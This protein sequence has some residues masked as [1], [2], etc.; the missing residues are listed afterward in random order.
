VKPPVPLGVLRGVLKDV[1]ASGRVEKPLVVGGARELAAVLRKELGRDGARGAVGAGDDVEGAAVLV[2][3]LGHEPGE[4][5]ERALRRARRARVP[6]VAVAAG[7]VPDVAIP[8]VLA[9]D[10]VRVKAG[11]G[12][13]IEAIARTIAARLGEDAA[14]LAARLPVLR[15]AICGWIVASCAR[16][17]AIV[18]VAV[19]FPGAD[20][21]IL[22]RNQVRMLLRLDQ[23]YGLK[24]DPRERAPEL[25]AVV[26]AGLG[27]RAAARELLDLV[28]V[29]GWV[30]KGV[31]AYAGTR[32][33]GEA[34]LRR[35]EA[36][37]PGGHAG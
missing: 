9:A 8:F 1:Q 5:D 15:G 23:A 25:L 18:A 19:F 33:L 3:V 30:V 28:P 22:A 31:V 12:F 34:A 2:Y 29:A 32:A 16:K 26:G 37:V 24:L 11:E 27:L 20:L 10:V 36:G 17:N 35:L 6:I 4:D 13:P 21:P 14:P 7:P